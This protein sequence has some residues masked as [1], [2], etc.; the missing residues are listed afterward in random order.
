MANALANR[1]KRMA[2]KGDIVAL[3]DT[4]K[5]ILME[6][7]FS[8]DKDA[9]HAYADVIANEVANGLGYTTGG[10]TLGGISLS[11][12]DANDWA[13]LSWDY[14]EWIPVGGSLVASGAIVYDDTTDTTSGHDYTDAI[15]YYI[16]FAETKTVLDGT[17][18]R[19][20]DV[21]ITIT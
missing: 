16:D 20:Q 5:I 4:F 18:L 19:I 2:L 12:D 13:K 14:A 9:H 8:F 11:V 17:N 1:F 3:T 6:T 7:G 10:E 15:V 21:Y